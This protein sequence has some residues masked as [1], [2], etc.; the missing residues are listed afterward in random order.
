MNNKNYSLSHWLSSQGAISFTFAVG[1][2]F[3]ITNYQSIIYKAY[4]GNK[5]VFEYPFYVYIVLSHI[6]SL[7]FG[8][9]TAII[10]FQSRLDWHKMLYGCFEALM[11]FLNLNRGF[12]DTY[13]LNSSSIMAGYLA[14]FT[15][16]TFYILGNISKNHF[17]MM[18]SHSQKNNVDL[19]IKEPENNKEIKPFS[20]LSSPSGNSNS[21]SIFKNQGK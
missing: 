12:L 10:I 16:F 3:L 4:T 13:G 7:F 18:I 17:E 20:N 2:I 6:S 15:G 19:L 21:N 1:I 9:A 11:I 5:V 14:I 8:L